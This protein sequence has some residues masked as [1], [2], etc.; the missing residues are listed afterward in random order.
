MVVI[1]AECG[2]GGNLTRVIIPGTTSEKYRDTNVDMRDD[3]P[4]PSGGKR[5]RK[6]KKERKKEETEEKKKKAKNS[7]SRSKR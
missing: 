5:E 6:G 2:S 1:Q 3:L 7:R 4:T